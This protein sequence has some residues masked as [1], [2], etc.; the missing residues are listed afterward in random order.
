MR[1]EPI[2]AYHGDHAVA[3]EAW[4]SGSR[5]ERLVCERVSAGRGIRA[6]KPAARI[7]PA[8]RV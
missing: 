8:R 5:R 3:E 6:V 1:V 7:A 2:A 4:V